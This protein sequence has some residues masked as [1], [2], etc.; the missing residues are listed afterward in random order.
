MA[1]MAAKKRPCRE[2]LRWFAPD[3]RVGGRQRTCSRDECQ[4]ARRA[5]TQAAWR[6]RHPEYDR[7]RRIQERTMAEAVG[8]EVSPSRAPRPLDRLPW[9]LA[10]DQFK[11]QGAEFLLGMGRVLRRYA[12]DQR[13]SQATDPT[14]GSPRLPPFVAQDQIQDRPSSPR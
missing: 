6:A 12:Q 1:A 3:A 13:A 5:A 4:R 14:D 2:C 7:A 10:Q 8:E 9:D 11:V